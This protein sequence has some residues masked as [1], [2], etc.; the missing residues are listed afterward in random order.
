MEL[1]NR[2]MLNADCSAF[3]YSPWKWLPEGGRYTKEVIHRY[4]RHLADMGIDTMLMNPN[5]QLPWYPSKN[6]PYVHEHYKRG[7]R[8]FMRAHMVECEKVPQQTLEDVL[9]NSVKTHDHYLDLIEEGTDWLEE[10]TIACREVGISPW[11]SVR[12]NDTHGGPSPKNS[13]FN[14][15]ILRNHPE[16]LMDKPSFDPK[17]VNNRFAL[18]YLKPECREFMTA[19]VEDVIMNYDY[20]GIELD[21]NRDPILVTPV[22]TDEER[23]VITE[24]LWLLRGIADKKAAL[25]GKKFYFGIK[26]GFHFSV[27]K[28]IGLD[29]CAYACSGMLDFVT[30]SN[31]YQTSWQQ[32][33]AEE[34][35]LLGDKVAIFGYIEG[36]VNWM[37]A[38]AEDTGRIFASY[39]IHQLPGDRTVNGREM[40]YSPEMMRG[41]AA[42]KLVLGA[43]GLIQYNNFMG[44]RQDMEE[45]AANHAVRNLN[46]LEYL[47]GLPKAYTFS[48]NGLWHLTTIPLEQVEQ[49]PALVGP[50][51]RRS[52]RLPMC[53]EPDDG[54]LY[55]AVQLIVEQREGVAF[56]PAVSVN[57]HWPV[58]QYEETDRLLYPAAVF[59]KVL[60]GCTAYTFRFPVSC[61]REGWNEFWVINM[62]E[63]SKDPEQSRK[64]IMK[65]AGLD[66]GIMKSGE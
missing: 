18:D 34:R 43:D 53:A 47:R 4:V 12:M 64:N 41:N 44:Y 24:W 17:K 32:D 37:G 38:R 42:G 9:D 15:N 57:E 55:L 48:T 35:R 20:E 27:L 39:E 10:V 21:F 14:N 26:T 11:L 2:N 45:Y 29:I 5:G 63:D 30:F 46:D 23:A 6:L 58:T 62:L 52:F 60:R 40:M 33:F 51:S 16:L 59:S 1:K 8:E 50:G 3:F 28:D 7:D 22:A 54:S 65:L 66:I 61:V 36:A 25:T 31:F 13:N 19:M 49:L 56:E